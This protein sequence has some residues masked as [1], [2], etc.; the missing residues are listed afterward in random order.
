MEIVNKRD[1]TNEVLR[2]VDKPSLIYWNKENRDK[3]IEILKLNGYI[4][5]KKTIR[6]QKLHPEYVEDFSGQIEVGFGNTDYHTSWSILYTLKI[7]GYRL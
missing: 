1:Y 5:R 7:C 6:N 2:R 4:C 3:A